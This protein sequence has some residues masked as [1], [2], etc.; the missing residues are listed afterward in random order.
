MVLHLYI[1]TNSGRYKFFTNCCF[2]IYCVIAF[3]EIGC[4][5]ESYRYKCLFQCFTSNFAAGKLQKSH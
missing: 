4:S 3:C 2:V 1:N 5:L